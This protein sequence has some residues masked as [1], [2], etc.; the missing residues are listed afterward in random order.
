[1]F[2]VSVVSD[3]SSIK[4]HLE[5]LTSTFQVEAIQGHEVND[6]SVDDQDPVQTHQTLNA[7]PPLTALYSRLPIPSHTRPSLAG[8]RSGLSHRPAARRLRHATCNT[9]HPTDIHTYQSRKKKF[10]ISTF[11][12]SMHVYMRNLRDE[13]KKD[14]KNNFQPK[15]DKY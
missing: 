9:P 14:P 5:P 2:L 8:H 12:S 6:L 3:T 11:R 15:S 10:L 4:N 7:R 13:W 1:M